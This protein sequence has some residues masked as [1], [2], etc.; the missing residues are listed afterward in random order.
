MAHVLCAAAVI[1]SVSMTR[2]DQEAGYAIDA[3]PVMA[4]HWQ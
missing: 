3:V 4:S 1:D 2:L